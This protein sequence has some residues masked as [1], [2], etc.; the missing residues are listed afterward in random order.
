[1][2]LPAKPHESAQKATTTVKKTAASPITKKS[3][4]VKT[5]TA[6]H[7]PRSYLAMMLLA[8]LM[9]PSG[10]ARAYRGDKSGWTRFWVY[11]GSNVIMIIPILGQLIGGLTLIV[12]A[13]MGAVDVFKLRKTTTDAFGAPLVMTEKDKQWAHGF[14]IYFIVTLVLIAL[15]I[16]LVTTLLGTAI[17]Q[18]VNDGGS[19]YDQFRPVD[20]TMPEQYVEPDSF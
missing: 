16:L 7:E 11:I 17:G 14:Y 3:S 20:S 12:L 8:V 5:V 18:Y 1:M 4:E 2:S 19:M 9:L 6:P 13:I 10:L 15:V